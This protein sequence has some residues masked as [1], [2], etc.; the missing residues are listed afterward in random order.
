LWKSLVILMTE[1]AGHS[2]LAFALENS[3]TAVTLSLGYF[4]GKSIHERIDQFSTLGGEKL[5]GL[6]GIHNVLKKDVSELKNAVRRYETAQQAYRQSDEQFVECVD[7]V[8]AEWQVEKSSHPAE[9]RRI[10]STAPP[11]I[12]DDRGHNQECYDL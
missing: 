11:A 2:R 5:K 3:D 6:A 7:R 12:Q 9:S 1:L 4:Q 8:V 10:V